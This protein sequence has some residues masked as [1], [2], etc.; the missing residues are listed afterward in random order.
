MAMRRSW[1][2]AWPSYAAALACLPLSDAAADQA[3]LHE[4]VFLGNSAG[5]RCK[6]GVC[7]A[8]KEV[9]AIEQ[10]GHLLAAPSD[11]PQP[12]PGEQVFTPE[13]E[14]APPPPAGGPPL[15]GDP[16]PE[17]RPMV[18]M[19]RET[20]P[21][22]AVSHTYHSV[23][24]PSEFPYKRMSVLDWATED[25]SLAVF[26]PARTPV[27]KLSAEMRRPDHDAFWGSIVIDL[28]PGRWIPLPSVAPSARLLDFRTEPP[29]RPG[30]IEFA[31][32][33]AD[34]FFVRASLSGGAGGQRRLIWLTDAPQ[35]YFS[36]PIPESRLDE[37]PRTLVRPLPLR[38]KKTALG[39]LDALG[40]RTSPRATLR[41]VLD[42]LVE[43]FRSFE[44]GALPTPSESNYRD[45]ALGKKGVCRHRAYAFAITAIAAGIPARYVENELHV[46]VEV[47]VPRLGWRR[48]NL[49]GAA[50]D[51]QLAGADDKPLHKPRWEDELPRPKEFL[52]NATPPAHRKGD[53]KGRAGRGGRAT[54]DGGDGR[55]LARIDLGA[56]LDA[57]VAAAQSQTGK[58]ATRLS[59]DIDSHVAFRG[60]TV[61]I[62]GRVVE[63]DGAGAADLTVEIYLDGAPGA[64]RVA[65]TRTGADG[66]F[67]VLALVPP[68]VQLGP[69][70][71]VART[72]GDARRLPSSS[73]T[74]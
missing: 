11:G 73:R 34:N 59:L 67:V 16:P 21:D 47:Y 46:F 28:E 3:V 57:D 35:I 7:T 49:G 72:A 25:E 24:T 42:P 31:K 68:A 4:R 19:D 70:G 40:I 27:E 12:A 69:Y 74:K 37:Q 20:G 23:F 1:W 65:E 56:V 8:G 22:A 64:E 29:V 54:G 9:R 33:G 13:P 30:A 36:G 58:L 5:M 39:V 63:H 2:I 18:R 10:D 15:P 44:T 53:G 38:V 50:L 45:L 26:E 6:G 66:R 55:A 61:E 60:D 52:S 48:I 14:H 32:D 41:S 62:T 43:H 51:D 17:R 71:V